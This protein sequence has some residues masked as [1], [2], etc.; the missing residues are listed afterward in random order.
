MKRIMSLALVTCLTAWGLPVSA[1]GPI[2]PE[3]IRRAVKELGGLTKAPVQSA[4]DVAWQRVTQLAVGQAVR[5]VLDDGTS[6]PGAFRAADGASI[7]FSVDGRNET[8]VRARIRQVS[9]SRGTHRKRN[10]LLGIAIGTVIAV[11]AVTLHCRGASS[12]C[13]Q[14][15]PAY[16]LPLAGAG[17]LIGAFLPADTAWR[18]VYP[19]PPDP[20]GVR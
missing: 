8:I 18:E 17:A 6:H 7:T 2:T 5:V 3:S 11:V 14:V 20:Q 13:N 15:A 4:A 12:G 16:S 9:E 1:D 19:T 10:V